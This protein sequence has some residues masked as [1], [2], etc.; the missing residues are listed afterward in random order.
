MRRPTVLAVTDVMRVYDL[1]GGAMLAAALSYFAFFTIVPSL[2][3]F[4]SLLGVL[5]EST[6]L[7]AQL[8]EALVDRLEPIEEIASLIVEGL[9]GTGRT[10]TIV[11]VL[12]LV[13]GASGFYG[14]LQDAMQRMLP[15][16]SSRGLLQT[17]VRGVLTVALILGSMLVAVVLIF[18]VPLVSEWLTARCRELG[19]VTLPLVPEACGLDLGEASAAV[20]VVATMVLAFLAA[21]AVYVIVP[22]HGAT[23]RQA[24]WPALIAGLAIGAFTTLFGWIAPLLV[25]QW[26]ALGILG[27]VFIALVWLN[28]VFQALIYGAA[29]ARL[30]R[31]R[32]RRTSRPVLE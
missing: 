14:A 22:M 10:G 12:G 8:I 6:D 19:D 4:V 26:L 13:W 24:F 30:H 1:G 21:L 29:L 5:V 20:A 31:D 7:R 11:G 32:E 25:R 27:S 28:L 9:A 18:T 3:L 16:P 17:R 2:L 15:G 23:L